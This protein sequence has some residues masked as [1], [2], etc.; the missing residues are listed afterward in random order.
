MVKD[1]DD[2]E[3]AAFES[4]LKTT[5]HVYEND[6]RSCKRCCNR[7]HGLSLAEFISWN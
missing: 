1:W 3:L 6:D 5:G 4:A 2:R 7:Q